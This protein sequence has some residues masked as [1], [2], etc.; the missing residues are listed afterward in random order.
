MRGS[1]LDAF[2]YGVYGH[3]L[4]L[5]RHDSRV[6]SSGLIVCC[7]IWVFVIMVW[8]S[9]VL[10]IIIVWASVV[11]F[12][13]SVVMVWVSVGMCICVYVCGHGLSVCMCDHG[14]N[15][16]SHGLSVW[17]HGS[18]ECNYELSV[19]SHA[20]TVCGRV[21]AM[22]VLCAC[23][24]RAVSCRRV[25]RVN[26][27]ASL[28][29]CASIPWPSCTVLLLLRGG[30]MPKALESVIV[31]YIR[32]LRFHTISIPGPSC[33]LLSW[34]RDGIPT[35]TESSVL[36]F[37]YVLRFPSM[38]VFKIILERESTQYAF[39]INNYIYFFL[40]RS[41]CGTLC[42]V[43]L[44]RVVLCCALLSCVL[45][46]CVQHIANSNQECALPW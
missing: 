5:C 45:L 19:R 18:S 13:V 23:S 24:V 34:L 2:N 25:W 41:F 40:L 8:M 35:A 7:M 1:G 16:C 20:L 6:S 12:C 33:T 31:P 3:G 29:F 39:R 11:T 43:V 46:R 42:N 21:L 27:Y 32:F 17:S 36:R 38:A 28:N 14:L 4:S 44:C 10:V 22:C 30:D 37:I 15:V 9:V 26:F